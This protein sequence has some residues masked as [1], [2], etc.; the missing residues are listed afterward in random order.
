MSNTKKIPEE[1]L[2]VHPVLF[3][4][5]EMKPIPEPPPLPPEPEVKE[6]DWTNPM[7]FAPL[8]GARFSEDGK[9]RYNLWRRFAEKGPTLLVIGVNPSKAGA[10]FND[11]TITRYE[12]FAKRDKFALLLAGNLLCHV[13][14]DP[15]DLKWVDDP[16][17]PQADEWLVKMRKMADVCVVAW[18]NNGKFLKRDQHVLKLLAP[19]GPL[20]CFGLN[21]TGTPKHLLYLRSD[22]KM[23]EFKP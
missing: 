8:A 18:G 21:K 5:G 10:D 17:G 20:H 14:T 7:P 2:L 1:N 4:V 9:H 16:I 6:I 15:D 3:D 19:L 13:A 22:T 11:P 12:G 23:I